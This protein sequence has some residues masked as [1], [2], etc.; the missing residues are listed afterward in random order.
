MKGCFMAHKNWQEYRAI[1]VKTGEV[2]QDVMSRKDF[3]ELWQSNHWALSLKLHYKDVHKDDIFEDDVLQLDI[4]TTATVVWD[5][6]NCR[7]IL[8]NDQ[9]DFRYPCNNY[10]SEWTIVGRRWETRFLSLIK[11]NSQGHRI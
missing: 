2:I 10:L 11:R 5:A 1:N 4:K 9:T 7:F 6:L 8:R 3:S